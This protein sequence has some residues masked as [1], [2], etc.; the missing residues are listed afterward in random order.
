[1]IA[2]TEP[3][4]GTHAYTVWSLINGVQYTPAVTNTVTL[5]VIPDSVTATVEDEGRDSNV[6]V[7]W[8]TTPGAVSFDV[9]DIAGNKVGSTVSRG[10]WDR[11]PKPGVGSYSVRAVLSGGAQG[12]VRLSNSLTLAQAPSS[13]TAA[14][15]TSGD[16]VALSWSVDGCG[17]HDQIQVVRGGASLAYLARGV[18]SYTDTNAEEGL[19]NSYQ[20]R[21]VI[22]GNHGPYS[23]TATS[24]VKALPPTSVKA[25]ATTTKGKLKLSW[26][27]PSGSRTGYEVQAYESLDAKWVNV[28]DTTP[29]SYHTFDLWFGSGPSD[30]KMRVRTLSAGGNSAWVEDSATPVWTYAP[31]VPNDVI[32]A[33]TAGESP[34][35]PGKLTLSWS[36]STIDTSHDAATFY[37]VET[38]TTGGTSDSSWTDRGIQTSPYSY[39][40]TGGSGARYMRVKATNNGGESGWVLRGATPS[41]DI[42][43]PALPTVTSWKPESSYGRMVFRC[44]TSSSDNS[45]YEVNFKVGSGG[46]NLA[47]VWNN[48]SNSQNLVL[49]LT[50]AP[51]AA[52]TISARIRVKDA[53]GNV[54][55]WTSS[56]TYTT[57][58]SPTTVWAT[59][60]GHWRNPAFGQNTGNPTRPYQG[61]YDNP[62]SEYAGYFWYGNGITNAINAA[63][64]RSVTRMQIVLYREGGGNNRDDCVYVGTTTR[65]SNPG[66][67]VA[68]PDHVHSP[69]CIGTL[70][71]GELKAFDLT[72]THVNNF[73]AGHKGIGLN[74]SKPYMFLYP[75]NKT[76]GNPA[77]HAGNGNITIH[78]L[79]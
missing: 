18:T 71:Y 5:G 3:L 61:Y 31:N 13:L 30:R 36:A 41:W 59:S 73:V 49:H 23:N 64:G 66:N 53:A 35:T 77:T 15:P 57:A 20:V 25:V 42:T 79:G 26:A 51:N 28:T 12:D 47:N 34:P 52:Q 70:R 75:Y 65:A 54:S 74:Q 17:H 58:V 37:I 22:S 1:L 10:I 60:S 45:K 63:S 78:H 21:A 56:K 29:P 9:F 55:G 7:E 14:A 76:I 43:P 69:A 72:G 50:T 40:F 4:S 48:C 2:D 24:S 33:G 68:N 44:K 39:T 11:N 27:N 38:S 19:V 46:W 6:M 8:D 62:G 16:N 67:V 32:I